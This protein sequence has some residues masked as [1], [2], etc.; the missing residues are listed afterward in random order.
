MHANRL[1]SSE[2]N[3]YTKDGTKKKVEKYIHLLSRCALIE[4][5]LVGALRIKMNR[6]LEILH[7]NISS[8]CEII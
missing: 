6:S 5:K 7:K 4:K 8:N 2:N 1:S 3:M